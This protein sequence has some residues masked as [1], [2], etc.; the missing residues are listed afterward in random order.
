MTNKCAMPMRSPSGCA[1]TT[2]RLATLGLFR[3]M[4]DV[5]ALVPTR[6]RSISRRLKKRKCN[7]RSCPHERSLSCQATLCPRLPSS[8]GG[9]RVTTEWHSSKMRLHRWPHPLWVCCHAPFGSRLRFSP[10]PTVGRCP[11]E[12]GRENFERK[13]EPKATDTHTQPPH[14]R[15]HPHTNTAGH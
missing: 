15:T 6:R 1:A 8:S 14:T 5:G 9:K 11:G 7:A 13:L 2:I 3:R 10:T 4:A 12:G